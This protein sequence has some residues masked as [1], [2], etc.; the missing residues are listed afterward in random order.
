[1]TTSPRPRPT[2]PRATCSH[3]QLTSPRPLRGGEVVAASS[4]EARGIATSPRSLTVIGVLARAR[5][6]LACARKEASSCSL[7]GRFLA[8]ARLLT[9]A[10]LAVFLAVERSYVYAHAEEL[11]AFRLGSGPRARLRFDRDEVLRRTSCSVSRE[12]SAADPAS[13]A[14]GRRGRRRRTGTDVELLPI[15]GRREDSN[16]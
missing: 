11:G 7:R 15:R 14:I 10:E 3:P 16:P 5:V 1:V 6:R 12:S 13:S 9:P 8:E 4:S 2:S